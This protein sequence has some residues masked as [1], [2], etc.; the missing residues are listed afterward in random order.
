MTEPN[1]ILEANEANETD[2]ETLREMTGA[3]DLRQP[4][5]SKDAFADV[6]VRSV[7]PVWKLPMPKLA[8]IGA[9]LVPVFGL[10]GYFLGGDR[11]EQQQAAL[12]VKPTENSKHP[13]EATNS[14]LQQ[15]KQEIA[16]LKSQMALDD[17]AYVKATTQS[18]STAPVANSRPSSQPVT[19][20]TPR[21][22]PSTQTVSAPA[23]PPTI[24]HRPPPLPIQSSSPDFNTPPLS[25]ATPDSFV[26]ADP[27]EQW[28]QLARLG[29]Y[30]ST[31]DTGTESATAEAFESDRLPTGTTVASA[32]PTAYFAQTSATIPADA[33]A[34][35]QDEVLLG[36]A[37]D[38]TEKESLD[39]PGEEQS[40]ESLPKT[41]AIPVLTEAEARILEEQSLG[42]SPSIQS[43]VMGSQAVGELVT[44]VVLDNEGVG[45]HFMVVL[46]EPL[47]DNAS[48]RAI[49][50]GSL[51][52]VQV[53][54]VA[55]NGLVQLSATEAIWEEQ[56]FQRELV[57]PRQTILIRGNGGDPL[58]AESY[59]DTGG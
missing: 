10:A 32:V 14:D 40:V 58:V 37:S 26:S 56:G 43:L 23:Q 22:L 50:A 39:K 29:S 20:S 27:F 48:H 45:D 33:S 19:T 44:P 6:E 5:V 1:Q 55:E 21:S 41:E 53:D 54:R 18:P 52:M 46:A 25:P 17:Q 11:T 38:T 42:T 13:E 30:G 35:F 12:P 28:Q 49:P 7:R 51:L 34:P 16:T 3:P 57:L 9:A 47:M 36:Q 31:G 59:G 15:A 2:E 24:S 4:L 8:L